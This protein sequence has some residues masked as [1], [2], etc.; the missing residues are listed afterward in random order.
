MT[1]QPQ[2]QKEPTLAEAMA[3]ATAAKEAAEKALAG[4]ESKDGAAA[5]DA[6]AKELGLPGVD[7][8]ALEAM[9]DKV[10]KMTA[11]QT[12]EAL[13]ARFEVE[14]P[15]NPTVSAE[16]TSESEQSGESDSTSQGSTAPAEGEGLKI[17]RTF[18][19]WFLGR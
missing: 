4:Q 5:A 15:V 16:S 13:A 1:D 7:T 12:V 19:D 3:I 17:P 6:K 2:E 9:L 8:G 14:N 10:S 11:D 18:A